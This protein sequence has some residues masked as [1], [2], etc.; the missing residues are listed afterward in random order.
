MVRNTML[1]L[2]TVLAIGMM[3]VPAY[4]ETQLSP[5][6]QFNMG[7][8]IGQ[9]QC[10]EN[11]VLM[12]S[13]SGRLSCITV[14]TSVILADR[15][16]SFVNYSDEKAHFEDS[17]TTITSLAPEGGHAFMGGYRADVSLEFPNSISIGEEFAINFVVDPRTD[18]ASDIL[19]T[20]IYH[21][22][23]FVP[24]DFEILTEFDS[25]VVARVDKYEHHGQYRYDDF[26]TESMVDKE[27][28][29]IVGSI[30]LKL[31]DEMVHEFDYFA[32]N[33]GLAHVSLMFEK[34]DG[35]A[36]LYK[37]DL[38]KIVEI[39]SDRYRND[40]V[41][42]PNTFDFD[43]YEPKA[44]GPDGLPPDDNINIY[45]EDVEPVYYVPKESWEY[46]AEMIRHVESEYGVKN[47]TSFIVDHMG[48]SKEFADEY[49][50]AYPEFQTQGIETGVFSRS[51][52]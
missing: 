17:T 24:T 32:L 45:P 2:F 8:P 21:H 3:T 35:G 36:I 4:A 26:F 12:L 38:R 1:V 51:N 40:G 19:D 10:N 44:L 13:N 28:N 27:K 48:F 29:T 47:F 39:E 33:A 14:D 52:I 49:I 16:F 43:A 31:N 20:M 50:E 9:I 34:T 22:T 15:G 30:N 46:F 7:I 11:K 18:N 42:D 5:L 23:G 37:G 25:L 6:K 41:D